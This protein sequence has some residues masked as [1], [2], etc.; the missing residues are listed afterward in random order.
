M[1]IPKETT[2]EDYLSD[3]DVAKKISVSSSWLRKQRHLRNK[4]EQ[5]ALD[6][7]AIYIGNS[8]R[9]KA[10]EINRWLNELA[11]TQKETL[12]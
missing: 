4:G 2:I 9:Y 6:V 7:D 11:Y 3:N 10:S 12:E 8:P 5:H 1:H